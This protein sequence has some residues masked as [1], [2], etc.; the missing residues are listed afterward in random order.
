MNILLW[1]ALAQGVSSLETLLDQ[2]DHVL[3]T[4]DNA[5]LEHPVLIKKNNIGVMT[6]RILE[7]E[8]FCTLFQE[9]QGPYYRWSG[10]EK[11]L[12][13][14]QGNQFSYTSKEFLSNA[15]TQ[16]AHLLGFYPDKEFSVTLH[17][18]RHLPI[19]GP[20]HFTKVT[21]TRTRLHLISIKLNRGSRE[22]AIIPASITDENGNR[23]DGSCY[24][25]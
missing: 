6:Y 16:T 15:F 24:V 2:H 19:T 9:C 13:T 23:V 17:W 7:E 14:L 22:K 11:P 21:T 20:L 4:R 12:Q 1:L 25:Y 18:D 3:C 5:T 10:D 8:M